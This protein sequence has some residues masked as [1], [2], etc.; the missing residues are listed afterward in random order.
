MT[1]ADSSTYGGSGALT[2]AT[3][4]ADGRFGGAFVFTTSNTTPTY[5]DLGLPPQLQM[6]GSQTFMAWLR[7]HYHG[8]DDGDVFSR[9]DVQV[10]RARCRRC[11]A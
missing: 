3:F 11:V 7:P 8:A 4:T 6:F 9:G 1:L 5:A 2:A 10:T